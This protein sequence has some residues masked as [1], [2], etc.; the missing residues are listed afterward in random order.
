MTL[1]GIRALVGCML[2]T[3]RVGEL[4]LVHGRKAVLDEELV[5]L[6]VSEVSLELSV[7]IRVKVLRKLGFVGQR[8][9]SDL[10]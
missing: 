3:S 10:S 7:V 8:F 2:L 5:L 6:D 1:H 9:S 4:D